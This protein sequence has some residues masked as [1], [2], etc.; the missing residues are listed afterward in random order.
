VRLKTSLNDKP[1]AASIGSTLAFNSGL[2][3]ICIPLERVFGTIY[4]PISF[5]YLL[6]TKQPQMTTILLGSKILIA[7]KNKRLDNITSC[8]F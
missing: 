3:L 7:I 2:T 1:I 6:Y 8:Q 4:H 5:S